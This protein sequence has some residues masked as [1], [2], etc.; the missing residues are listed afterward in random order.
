MEGQDDSQ[1]DNIKCFLAPCT[2]KPQLRGPNQWRTD[3]PHIQR[4]ENHPSQQEN[5]CSSP[6]QW[7]SDGPHIQ[8]PQNRPCQQK[9]SIL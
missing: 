3:G 7:R 6:N 2:D 9:C 4:L 5:W 1:P 8:R